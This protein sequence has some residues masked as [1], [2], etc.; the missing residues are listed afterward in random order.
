MPI[1][2]FGSIV[3]LI[4]HRGRYIYILELFSVVIQL[5]QAD[6]KPINKVLLTFIEI[7]VITHLLIH[8]F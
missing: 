5:P 4:P 3:T 6:L 1:L 8:L 2:I 7:K